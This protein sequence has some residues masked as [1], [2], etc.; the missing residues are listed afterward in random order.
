MEFVELPLEGLLLIKPQIFSD[1]RGFFLE[2][3]RKDH[4]SR[5]SEVEFVQENHSLSSYKTIRGMHFQEGIGQ[6]KLVRVIGGK[7][8]D[9]A[10]DMRKNSKTY[11][12][13]HGVYLDDEKCEQ[14]FIPV[15]FA[16]GFCVLSPQAHLL[17]KVSNYYDP[18]LD[19]G[20]VWNDPFIS[21]SW[22]ITE[23]ILSQKDKTAPLFSEIIPH[24][25]NS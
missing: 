23:P 2:S 8:F 14:L 3:F 25:I 24:G 16:H 12:Q 10:V 6:G 18:I 5:C 21:I 1:D 20:F 4:F 9:V 13:W 15:G 11:G 17:Y 22:P 19:R 7:I